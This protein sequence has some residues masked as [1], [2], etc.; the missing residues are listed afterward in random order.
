MIADSTFI[1]LDGVSK[2]YNVANAP[3]TINTINGN[4]DK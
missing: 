1:L 3:I 2:T 4:I